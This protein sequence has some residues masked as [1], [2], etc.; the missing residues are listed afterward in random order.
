MD[1]HG[2]SPSRSRG[3]LGKFMLAGGLV[4]AGLLW[5]TAP[6][7]LLGHHIQA[8]AITRAD[9]PV[10]PS[11][12]DNWSA[13]AHTLG[14]DGTTPDISTVGTGTVG[15]GADRGCRPNAIRHPGDPAPAWVLPRPSLVKVVCR[16]GAY[17]KIEHEG[18]GGWAPAADVVAL[19][20]DPELCSALDR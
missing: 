12:P 6:A 14:A 1:P 16:L 17:S 3:E 18:R 19:T 13:C 8:G 7:G 2:H 5:V 9:V 4:L 20:G 10:Y 11:T 15:G